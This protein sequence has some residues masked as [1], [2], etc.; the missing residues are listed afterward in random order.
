M[1]IK[2]WNK[3]ADW[4]LLPTIVISY[5]KQRM[6]TIKFCFLKLELTYFKLWKN[7]F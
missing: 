6:L 2:V 3:V 4:W 7:Q 1:L 5:K